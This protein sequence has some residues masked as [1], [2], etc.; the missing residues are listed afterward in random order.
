M[1]KYLKLAIVESGRSQ[2]SIAA[3]TRIAENRLSSIV[4]GWIAPTPD[5]RAAL[6]RVL[7]VGLEA[8]TSNSPELETRSFRR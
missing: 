4:N 8:F 5:E 2:R 6:Q 3:E 7:G 1:R